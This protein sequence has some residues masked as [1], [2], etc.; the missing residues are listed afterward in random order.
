M[1]RF[2]KKYKKIKEIGRGAYGKI[3]LVEN[4]EDH[5]LVVLK[6]VD[7]SRLDE[8]ETNSVMNEIKIMEMLHHQYVVRIFD[9]II[10]KKSVS[11]VMQYA[12]GQQE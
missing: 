1:E 8:Q 10:L 5:V 2:N 9:H 4:R 6:V 7:L 3:F 11:I 12:E